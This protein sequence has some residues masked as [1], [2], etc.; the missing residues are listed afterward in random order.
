MRVQVQL[1]IQIAENVLFPGDPFFPRK[2]GWEV[3][4]LMLMETYRT[5]DFPRGGWGQGRCNC[6]LNHCMIS[7]KL[8]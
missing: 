8:E 2:W 7:L 4:L 1:T 5:C 6:N 3:L